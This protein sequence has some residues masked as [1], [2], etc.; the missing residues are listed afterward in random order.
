MASSYYKLSIENRT[1][2]RTKG[3]K[4]LK[5]NDTIPGVLYYKGDETIN[6]LTGVIIIETVFAWPGIGKLLI[7]S[8]N[9]LD[10]PVVVSYIMMT[11]FIFLIINLIVDLAM[12][13]I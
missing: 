13:Q 3:A 9:L 5:R 10:R 12:E 1:L 2:T 7:D 4:S 11:V 8:I 6:V